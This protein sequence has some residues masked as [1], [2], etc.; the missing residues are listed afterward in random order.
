MKT[1]TNFKQMYLVDN[2]QYNKLNKSSTIPYSTPQP[3]A[4]SNPILVPSAPH[5]HALT[6]TSIPTASSSTNNN[7]SQHINNPQSV[8][9][10]SVAHAPTSIE[11]KGNVSQHIKSPR[12]HAA[13][14]KPSTNTFGEEASNVK[15]F[16]VEGNRFLDDIAQRKYDDYSNNI[17]EQRNIIPKPSHQTLSEYATSKTNQQ[18]AAFDIPSNRALSIAHDYQHPM[19]YQQSKPF[20]LLQYRQIPTTV[21]MHVDADDCK[22]CEDAQPTPPTYQALPPPPA[23]PSLPAPTPFLQAPQS[24]LTYPALIPSYPAIAPPVLSS[25]TTSLTHSPNINK[26]ALPA[27]DAQIKLSDSIPIQKST[28]PALAPPKTDPV[29]HPPLSLVPVPPPPSNS[30]VKYEGYIKSKQ[31]PVK[32]TYICTRCNNTSFK[33]ESSLINHNNRFHAAFKQTVKGV[34][35]QSKDE[36][37]H[38]ENKVLKLSTIKRRLKQNEGQSKSRR[39]TYDSYAQST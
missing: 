19:E 13:K 5:S 31:I 25:H 6:I 18:A 14:Q 28:I 21:D 37:K 1:K 9:E 34:K 27:P 7:V 24:G 3:T 4:T 30:P 39:L 8:D 11:V 22:E 12:S 17:G 35:R 33:K 20:P 10:L 36:I 38:G 2:A 29:H 26:L 32:M 23:Y 16:E 15:P